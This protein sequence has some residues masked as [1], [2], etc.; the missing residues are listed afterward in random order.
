M[1]MPLS[2]TNSSAQRIGSNYNT[3]GVYF[4]GSGQIL[5]PVIFP[6]VDSLGNFINYNSNY[7]II[8]GVLLGLAVIYFIA[9]K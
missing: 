5:P 3:G 6:A 9:K 7:V 1:G 4:G 2:F 8:I